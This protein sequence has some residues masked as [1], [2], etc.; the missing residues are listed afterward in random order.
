[1]TERLS[2]DNQLPADVFL[3]QAGIELRRAE[4]YRIF[5]S[6]IIFDLSTAAGAL[7]E[8]ADRLSDEIRQ[9]VRSS[10]H[11]AFIDRNRIAILF[12]ETSRQGA[13][14]TA[15][16]LRNVLTAALE[17]DR[18]GDAEQL[19]PVEM[20]SFPDTGGAKPIQDLLRDLS[21]QMRN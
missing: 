7:N 9:N 1:M 8:M 2:I 13:E 18:S 6:L 21:E 19:I 5:V 11:F 14:V 4:R 17:P 20:V 3:N 12:P 16:R 10:D 15:R